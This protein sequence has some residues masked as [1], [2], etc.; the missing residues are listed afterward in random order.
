MKKLNGF[1]LFCLMSLNPLF[2]FILNAQGL[3]KAAPEDDS[4]ITNTLKSLNEKPQRLKMYCKKTEGESLVHHMLFYGKAKGKGWVGKI[5]TQQLG[6]GGRVLST[7]STQE[8]AV[9]HSDE[10]IEAADKDP[11]FEF[12]LDFPTI[13]TFADVKFKVP[14]KGDRTPQSEAQK[15]QS[16]S[17]V[18]CFE[19]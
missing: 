1:V 10:V 17:E 11:R 14:Y 16:L 6:P 12:R 4:E 18:S 13:N 2:P 8:F 15:P 5:H 7:K 9:K 19:Q 3:E